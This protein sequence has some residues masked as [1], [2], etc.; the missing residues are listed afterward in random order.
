MFINTMNIKK[1]LKICL[2]F[3][4]ASEIKFSIKDEL[5]LDNDYRKKFNQIIRENVE[6]KFGIYIWVN[7]NTNEILYI[8]KAGTIKQDG[9]FSKHT[10]RDRLLASRGKDKN[11]KDVQTNEF[12][13]KFM[14]QGN[15]KRV[16]VYLI[17]T[18][19]NV[20][21]GYLESLLLNNYFKE[22]RELPIFNKHF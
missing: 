14:E 22:N 1:V 19:S 11:G 5:F 10:V 12:F 3:S 17:Y 6:R 20:S 4:D 2:P 18:I 16:D 15:I 21:P 8:G 13:K 9:Q 7:S